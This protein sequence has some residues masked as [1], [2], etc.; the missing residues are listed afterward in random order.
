MFV[1]RDDTMVSINYENEYKALVHNAH[2]VG[3]SEYHLQW[4]TKYRYNVL[5]G[6]SSWKDCETSIR[7]AAERHGIKIIELGVM[8]D[9]VHVVAELPPDM[10]VSHAI[11]LLKGASSY[12]MFRKHPEVKRR[13][14]GGNFWGRGYFYKSVSNVTDNVI[15]RYVRENNTQRQ[16]KLT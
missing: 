16:R 1:V 5:T 10:A 3:A 7:V 13:Y 9:H 14:W 12:D 15:R 11:G 2:S 6:E 4:V 8:E